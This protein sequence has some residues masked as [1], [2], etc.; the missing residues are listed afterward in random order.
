MNDVSIALEHVHLL[1]SLNW[2]SVQL[3]QGRLKLLVVVGTSGNVA[4][5]LV[6]RGSLAA[7]ISN[8]IN[9]TFS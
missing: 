5:L 8:I 6:S 2:L 9:T 3:L 7:Y 1:D 4:L